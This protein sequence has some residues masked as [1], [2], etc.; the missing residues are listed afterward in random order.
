MTI[1]R[2]ERLGKLRHSMTSSRSEP[3]DLPVY[4]ILPQPTT[5]WGTPSSLYE[6]KTKG[7][8]E[9]LLEQLRRS[10]RALNEY[11]LQPRQI[12]FKTD[13]RESSA[14]MA[15]CDTAHEQVLRQF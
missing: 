5:V 14:L 13:T 1:V 6:R 4:R 10:K 15:T 11:T 12:A 9:A 7:F 8:L 2:L 3:R